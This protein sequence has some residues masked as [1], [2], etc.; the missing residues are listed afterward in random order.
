MIPEVEVSLLLVGADRM[1]A[2][3]RQHRGVDRPT[4]VLS[5]PQFESGEPLPAA[6][7]LSLGD[8]VVCWPVLQAQA[9]RHGHHD[10]DELAV[11]LVH[12]TLHL[13]GQDHLGAGL[14]RD[15]AEREMCVLSALGVA[16]ELALVGRQLH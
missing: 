5:F 11:L 2:L 1:R 10:S 8:L 6:G 4:D 16:P 7:P 12:G 9:R 13:L 14:A 3:N 15:M